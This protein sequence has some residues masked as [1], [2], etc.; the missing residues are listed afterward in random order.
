MSYQVLVIWNN[1]N[2][3]KIYDI[4]KKKNTEILIKKRKLK[5]IL[6][7]IFVNYFISKYS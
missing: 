1:G 3:Y 5:P 4:F 6:I 7:L 2:N